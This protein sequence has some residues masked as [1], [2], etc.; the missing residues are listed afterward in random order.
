MNVQYNDNGPEATADGSYITV[1]G[2]GESLRRAAR[3]LMVCQLESVK[4]ERHK[5]L[6]RK[7]RN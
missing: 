7:A 3:L 6:R 4:H 1:T 2:G 5:G